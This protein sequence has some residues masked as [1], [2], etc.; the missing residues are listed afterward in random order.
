MF[1]LL[2]GEIQSTSSKK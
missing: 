1:Y 2:S